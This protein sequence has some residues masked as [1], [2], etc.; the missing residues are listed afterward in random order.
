MAAGDS[1]A[2]RASI[3]FD[4]NPGV[5]TNN[6]LTIITQADPIPP[7]PVITGLKNSYCSIGGLQK[8]KI[9]NLPQP[10]NGT[11]VTVKL[12]A[13]V[14]PIAADSTFSFNPATAGAG[15]HQMLISFVNSTGGDSLLYFIIIAPAST[16]DVN[17]GANTGTV[18]NLT[19]PVIITATNAAG[20]G[21]APKYT[22]AKD[23]SFTNIIQAESSSAT[24]S[25]Q[26]NT[27][28]VGFNKIFVLMKTSDTCFTS[29]TGIDSISIERSAITGITDT[30][31]PNQVI[32]VYPNPFAGDIN[33]S[34]LNT[35]K[36]YTIHLSNA[37]GQKVYSQQVSNSRT[38]SITKTGLQSGKYWLSIY[39]TRKH[40]LIGTALLIKE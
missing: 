26:P 15:T 19:D 24:V 7:V 28:T 32:N 21:T 6:Q 35:G 36:Q 29:Q 34:G 4:F 27:L 25:I 33:I 5:K 18:V 12:D 30:D 40:Q 13:T 37:N 22:F 1:I 38:V 16:P 23:K 10:G 8:V 2:N 31:F 14:L 9:T 11:T 3:Y 20:G 39:D 17:L